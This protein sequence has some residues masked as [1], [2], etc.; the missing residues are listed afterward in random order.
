MTPT[1]FTFIL[2]PPKDLAVLPFEKELSNM[3]SILNN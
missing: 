1:L 3:N 2:R